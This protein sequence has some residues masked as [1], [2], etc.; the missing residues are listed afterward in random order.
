MLVGIKSC[1]KRIMPQPLMGLPQTWVFTGSEDS[2]KAMRKWKPPPARTVSLK[3]RSI[4]S[5]P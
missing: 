1:L 5:L 2:L 4:L 3:F